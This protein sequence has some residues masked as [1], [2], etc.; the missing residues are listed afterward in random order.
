MSDIASLRQALMQGATGREKLEFMKQI[1]ELRNQAKPLLAPNGKPSNLNV[2]QHAQVRTP[3]FKAWFG[4][5]EAA[6]PEL[7]YQKSKAVI[8]PISYYGELREIR[9]AALADYHSLRK[10]NPDGFVVSALKG[11]TKHSENYNVHLEHNEK[12]SSKTGD[13][14]KFQII[15]KL[16]E[17]LE[18][19]TWYGFDKPR[20][21]SQL[22]NVDGYHY[23]ISKADIDGIGF[24]VA[25]VV[26]EDNNGNFYHNHTL[27]RE[28]GAQE[29]W[30]ELEESS[31]QRSN[32]SDIAPQ[33]LSLYRPRPKINTDISPESVDENGE[34]TTQA[35]NDFLNQEKKPMLDSILRNYQY[36]DAKP[37]FDRAEPYDTSDIETLRTG[38]IFSPTGRE[39]LEFMKQIL[40]LRSANSAL[41]QSEEYAIWGIP[42]GK[43]DEELLISN[44]GTMERAINACK[45]LENKHGVTNTR[46]QVLDMQVKPDFISALTQTEKTPPETPQATQ[47]A[48]K[49]ALEQN[50]DLETFTETDLIPDG[51]DNTVKTAK[52]TKVSTGFAVIEA[53]KLIVSHDNQ[54]NENPEYPYE[55]QPRDRKRAESVAWVLKTAKNLDVDSLGKTRRADS[56]APII[57]DLLAQSP[58]TQ[59]Q[60]ETWVN[61]Q[62]IDKSS[63]K[64][65]QNQGYA[66]ED[67]RKDMVEF[68]RISGGNLRP[69]CSF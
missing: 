39:K 21:E 60:A 54:G 48:D 38:I 4:D 24:D 47:N 16:P 42:K 36:A 29:I 33:D 37:V 53:N 52:G 63:L 20:K 56:G 27:Y 69:S 8:V 45:S 1:I 5:F 41:T 57:T 13:K 58:V 35:I 15:P 23:V 3:E 22:R 50:P 44:A 66:K 68:Y 11:K 64:P 59:E 28:K 30:V 46:I 40:A 43:T 65:L 62:I 2:M 51:D 32:P 26:R 25:F 67:V 19:A 6:A 17:L 34:P 7:I 10:K 49:S 12:F 9:D 61:A 31:N 18:N 55:L 14:R